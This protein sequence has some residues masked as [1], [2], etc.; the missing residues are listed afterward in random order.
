MTP[1]LAPW[2]SSSYFST[3]PHTPTPI[4]PNQSSLPAPVLL[5]THQKKRNYTPN[6]MEQIRAFNCVA[7]EATTTSLPAVPRRALP[8]PG[9]PSQPALFSSRPPGLANHR[10]H[11]RACGLH[12]KEHR[13]HKSAESASTAHPTSRENGPRGE[14]LVTRIKS[15]A[16]DS[17]RR[18]LS[19][20]S[21]YFINPGYRQEEPI[22]SLSQNELLGNLHGPEGSLVPPS[23]SADSNWVAVGVAVGW[24]SHWIPLQ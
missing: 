23:L 12:S 24:P 13:N 8:V 1:L 7:P 20:T 6:A 15:W 5:E 17:L 3:G 2:P 21:S 14:Q 18:A 16:L 22:T 11:L 10:T 4:H 9:P 19:N